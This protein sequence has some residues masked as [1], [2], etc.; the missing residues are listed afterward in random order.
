MASTMPLPVVAPATGND[1]A[2]KLIGGAAAVC[3]IAALLTDIVYARDPDMVWVTFSV[4]A[5]TIG[6][7]LA[8]VA[9]L[10]GLIARIVHGRLGQVGLYWPYLLGFAVVVVIEIFNAFVH[11]RDAYQAVVPEGITL[12]FLAVL[13]LVLTPIA[14]RAYSRS[15]DV[16]RTSSLSNTPTRKTPF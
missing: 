12:S 14:A 2:F 11:S 13:I 1:L 16:S 4:W 3:F 9:T 15:R 6:L 10:V 7:I 5:V 8:G